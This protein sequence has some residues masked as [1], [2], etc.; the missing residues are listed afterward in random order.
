MS[1]ATRATKRE[2]RREMERLMQERQRR[3]PARAEP[4]GILNFWAERRRML[5]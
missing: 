2:E 3:N 1:H 4:N 5:T